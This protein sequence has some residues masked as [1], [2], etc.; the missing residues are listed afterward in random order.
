MKYRSFGNV[1]FAPSALG[2]GCMRLPVLDGDP[3][4]VDEPLA[5]SMMRYAIDHG[6][7]Y[8]DTAYNYHR[9]SSE[10]VLGKALLDGYRSKVKIATKMP[11]YVLEKPEDADRCFGE[12][13]E[14]LG[15]GKVDFYLLHSLDAH[16]WQKAKDLRLL[17]W[18]DKP[19]SEGRIG[20]FGF[21]FHDGFSCFKDIIDSYDG[22]SFC[23]VQYNYV[24]VR[25][26]AGIAG[27]R[28]AADKGLGVVIMEPLRGGALAKNIPAPVQRLL[29]EAGTGRTPAD[30]ALQWLWNQPEV[31][32]VL[33]GMSS[34]R[35]VVENVA[36]AERSGVGTLSPAEA[37]IVE[38]AGD[39]FR[40]LISI[41]C[42]SCGYCMP[43]PH[44][45]AIPVNFD[46]YNESK[47]FDPGRPVSEESRKAYA[48]FPKE[49]RADS[50]TE[51]GTCEERCPQGLPIRSLLKKIRSEMQV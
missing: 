17:E 25:N 20:H 47:G 24:D 16:S 41:P 12:Q 8:L 39:A 6:V 22:W 29:D 31:S 18:V 15:V 21:S 50:C 30:L 36:S 42:T 4:K 1:G 44:G 38:Q 48:R 37:R 33:S 49:S 32:V 14:R 3:S 43:C 11:V 45:L 23:Q 9:G 46:V 51:C 27:L 10:R 40:S 19:L 28:Y 2:F 35:E 7:N 34:M 5:I 26:Q 13:L